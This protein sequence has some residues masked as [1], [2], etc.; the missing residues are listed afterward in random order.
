MKVTRLFAMGEVRTV[1][2]KKDFITSFLDVLCEGL[3]VNSN[4]FP[5]I[6][7]K[8]KFEQNGNKTECS[9]IELAY[10]FD[11]NYKK[12]RPSDNILKVIPFSSARKRMTSVYQ[13]E[14]SVRVFSKGAPDILID[15]C[16]RY[17]NK[18][19]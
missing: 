12:Y 17:V 16:K 18:N 4:A 3:C 10:E 5:T 13:S 7:K 11:Y 1:F 8:G 19:G 9:L 15:M 14:K 2:E 6:D